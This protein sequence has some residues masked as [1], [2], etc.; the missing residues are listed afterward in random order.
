MI[1][2]GQHICSWS[3]MLGQGRSAILTE[4]KCHFASLVEAAHA[5][6]G[7]AQARD[8]QSVEAD[9]ERLR[10]IVEKKCDRAF[11][12]DFVRL[13]VGGVDEPSLQRDGGCVVREEV[14]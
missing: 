12:L 5:D 13:V 3:G 10:S 9:G 2:S 7:L 8:V 6:K 11:A 14:D 1:A 4:M